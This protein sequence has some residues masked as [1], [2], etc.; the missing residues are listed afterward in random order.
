MGALGNEMKITN[1]FSG[2]VIKRSKSL[3]M[4]VYFYKQHFCIIQFA[5]P[6]GNDGVSSSYPEN[7][8]FLLN[9]FL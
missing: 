7:C 6:L 5:N 1:K 8:L 4:D 9:V 2:I 3:C